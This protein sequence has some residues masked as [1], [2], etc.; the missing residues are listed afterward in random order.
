MF[1]EDKRKYWFKKQ[2]KKQLIEFCNTQKIV[3]DTSEMAICL[4]ELASDIRQKGGY[5]ENR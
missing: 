5:I 1:E 2:L 4:E 3:L